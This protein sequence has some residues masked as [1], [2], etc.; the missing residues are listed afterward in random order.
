MKE[1]VIIQAELNAP[2][3]QRNTFGK[4]NYRSC[5]DIVEAVKPLLKKTECTLIITDSIVEVGGRVYVKATATITNKDNQS[6]F[7]DGFAREADQKKGMDPAQLTGAT[8]SYARK[9]ACNGLFCI[10]DNKDADATNDHGKGA[11]TTPS[12]QVIPADQAN[13]LLAIAQT[14]NAQ[15]VEGIK[16]H[17]KIANFASTPA[18]WFDA[19]KQALE[20][21]Q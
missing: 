3:N 4:Y 14:K 10:D 8:S 21:I 16:K 2:K 11:Q 7:S 13:A 1:L 6:V 15:T 20:G 5:E 17:F 18:G 12:P 9:Y 19:V